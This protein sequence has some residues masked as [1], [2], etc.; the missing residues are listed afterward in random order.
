MMYDVIIVGG[1]YAGLQTA[2]SLGRALRNVLVIDSGKPCNRQ[3]PHSHNFITQ[4]GETPQA[5]AAKAKEQV[6]QYATIQFAKGKVINAVAR[7][8]TFELS[9]EAGEHYQAR[10]VLFATGIKDVMPEIPGFAECWGI[11]VIHCPYC[12]GYEVR[13]RRTGIIGNGDIGYEYVKMINN[14]S[15]DI[16]LFTNGPSTLTDEQKNKL[17]GKNIS[18]IEHPVEEIKHDNGYL[19]QVLAGEAFELD[20]LYCRPPF[21]QHSN[22]PQLLGCELNDM[23]YIKL[24]ETNQTTVKGVYAAGDCV[25]PARSIAMAVYTGMMSGVFINKSLNDADF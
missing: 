17:A 10:K 2:M 1:S 9:T 11:S 8:S 25:S 19:T 15:K 23:G 20:A 14:W 7:D 18:I 3:T 21:E 4:D 12:H 13:G 24:D 16:T 6:K 22:V 5:V